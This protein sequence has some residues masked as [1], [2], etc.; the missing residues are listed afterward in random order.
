MNINCMIKYIKYTNTQVWKL[1]RSYIIY[2][3][4]SYYSL[5][6]IYYV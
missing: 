6:C 2:D 1:T 4:S 3:I 5:C